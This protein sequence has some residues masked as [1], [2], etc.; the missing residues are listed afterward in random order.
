MPRPSKYGN[1][2]ISGEK[3]ASVITLQDIKAVISQSDEY[4]QLSFIEGLKKLLDDVVAI[5][6]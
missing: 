1:V 3:K 6:D 5:D 2:R 4:R